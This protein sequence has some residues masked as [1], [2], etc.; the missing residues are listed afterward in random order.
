LLRSLVEGST[1]YAVSRKAMEKE[2]KHFAEKA[3]F[4][5]LKDGLIA[6]NLTQNFFPPNKHR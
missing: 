4:F 3:R 2:F 1:G 5:L 6:F